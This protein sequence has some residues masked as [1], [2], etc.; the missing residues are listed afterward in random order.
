VSARAAYLETHVMSAE[1]MELVC[2]LYQHAID[3]VRDARGNLERGDIAGRGKAISK[4]IGILGELTSSLNKEAGGT[5]CNSLEQLYSYMTL[6][7]T[8][9]NIR[10]QDG[11]LAEVQ[12]L[13][14]T[15]SQA[16]EETRKR[17]TAPPASPAIPPA[18]A[19]QNTSMEPVA[20]GWNA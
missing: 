9:A 10:K 18:A 13:L 7:L 19:W 5:L 4:A 14:A 8:E 1:P 11:P 6:R 20:H 15:L 2:L 16:W 17:Q 12:N 3:A